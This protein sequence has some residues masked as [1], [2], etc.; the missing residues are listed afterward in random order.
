M[1][2]C[3]QTNQRTR[4][5]NPCVMPCV[6]STV[7]EFLRTIRLTLFETEC[8]SVC[9]FVCSTGWARNEDRAGMEANEHRQTGRERETTGPH[10]ASALSGSAG[11]QSNRRTNARMEVNLLDRQTNR[12]ADDGKQASTTLH[13]LLQR[14]QTDQQRRIGIDCKFN[15]Q[16]SACSIRTL[17]LLPLRRRPFNRLEDSLCLP[18]GEG[19]M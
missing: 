10:A 18:W 8:M 1:G 5:A 3:N 14:L 16:V 2:R 17:A 11:R 4:W 15:A 9:L 13:P 19:E 6:C 12:Q 7:T